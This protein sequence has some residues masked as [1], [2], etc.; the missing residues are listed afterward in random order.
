MHPSGVTLL[1]QHV[2]QSSRVVRAPACLRAISA[3]VWGERAG[4]PDTSCSV[5]VAYCSTWC[6]RAAVAVQGLVIVGVEGH[7]LLKGLCS[8]TV[9]GVHHGSPSV[10][11]TPS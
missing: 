8:H 2:L 5:D 9:C 1:A 7:L 6:A 4:S 11:V 10:S 3:S